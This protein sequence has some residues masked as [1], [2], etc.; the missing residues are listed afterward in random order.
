MSITIPPLTMQAH[1][2]T[3]KQITC[4]CVIKRNI[5]R[6]KAFPS[7]HDTL[8]K[9]NTLVL[10]KIC[11]GSFSCLVF[12]LVW[13]HSFFFTLYSQRAYFKPSLLWCKLES[14]GEVL[15]NT[16]QPAGCSYGLL[17][18]ILCYCGIRAGGVW[19]VCLE[20]SV[21][22]PGRY[23]VSVCTVVGV[24]LCVYVTGTANYPHLPCL[25]FCFQFPVHG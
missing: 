1:G 16:G 18:Y 4:L 11:C 21:R 22:G 9:H 6:A 8:E 23:A 24:C 15:H 13:K 20:G 5:A 7:T 12:C 17:E 14:T 3:C 10:L 19:N 25:C 2:A